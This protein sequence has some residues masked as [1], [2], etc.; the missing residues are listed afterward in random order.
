MIWY[1]HLFFK[2][3]IERA[4]VIQFQGATYVLR[5][6]FTAAGK[7][8]SSPAWRQQGWNIMFPKLGKP[9]QKSKIRCV[10]KKA[11]FS[12]TPHTVAHISQTSSKGTS[13]PGLFESKLLSVHD[14][15]LR[16][17]AS[18]F[19]LS[20]GSTELW[21]VA[22]G[23]ATGFAFHTQTSKLWQLYCHNINSQCLRVR[24]LGFDLCL[25]FCLRSS[26]HEVGPWMTKFAFQQWKDKTHKSCT[27]SFVSP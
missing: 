22:S 5:M 4:H 17:M 25:W 16:I 13:P 8:E 20:H 1:Y 2:S 6:S 14:F 11:A 12:S 24:W 3:L 18:C 19:V 9:L 27:Y 26:L 23:K 15:F 7:G 10:T 21:W